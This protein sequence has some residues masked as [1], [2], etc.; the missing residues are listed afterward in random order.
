MSGRVVL[1]AGESRRLIAG[2]HLASPMSVE[3]VSYL[4]SSDLSSDGNVPRSLSEQLRILEQQLNRLSDAGPVKLAHP[5]TRPPTSLGRPIGLAPPPR[6]PLLGVPERYDDEDDDEGLAAAPPRRGTF[7][8][9]AVIA[10]ASLLLLASTAVVPPLLWH[11]VVPDVSEPEPPAILVMRTEQF[12]HTARELRDVRLVQPAPSEEIA[13]APLLSPAGAVPEAAPE[14]AM[15]AGQEHARGPTRPRATLTVA[16]SDLSRLSLPL[17]VS[18]GGPAWAGSAVVIDGLPTEARVSHGMKIA[19]DTWTVGIAD[20]G[21]AV[22]SLPST[23]PDRLELSVRVLG[24]DSHEL[25]VSALQIHVL[26]TPDRPAPIAPAAIFE[27]AAAETEKG[28]DIGDDVASR[29]TA[30]PSRA[31]T[32]ASFPARPTSLPV[33]KPASQPAP[34][35][36]TSAWL[37]TLQPASS[38][39]LTPML[40]WA[41]FSDR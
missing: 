13:P 4:A 34:P 31:Q 18:G 38:P 27:P 9:R 26:R 6:T 16:E 17:L 39:S 22:L 11:L 29:P 21:Y 25:A 32:P 28:P 30:K 40:G 36:A 12:A 14:P 8:R 20:V 5:T 15:D 2:R 24:A 35:T 1:N 33:R 3:G 7:Q 10:A 23:T 41:P 37:S 19:P